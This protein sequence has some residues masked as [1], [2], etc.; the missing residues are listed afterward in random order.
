MTKS[1]IK[2]PESFTS[3]IMSDNA[4]DESIRHLDLYSRLLIGQYDRIPEMM[5]CS[6]CSASDYPI[7]RDVL[8]KIRCIFIPDLNHYGIYTSNGIWSSK[9]PERAIKAYDI[10][11]ALRFQMSWHNAK[12]NYSSNSVNYKTPFFHGDWKMTDEEITFCHRVLQFF[13]YPGCQ[14]GCS[15]THKWMLPCV[16]TEY[17]NEKKEIRLAMRC[18]FS[19]EENEAE[20][21]HVM[22][23]AQKIWTAT[24]AGDL[25]EV[26]EFEAKKFEH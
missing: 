24:Q 16:I 7:L 2:I 18:N 15:L 8:L 19:H 14:Q 13:N 11:Q 10:Q 22:K 20:I 12:P 9:S 17:C 4:I 6:V 26:S 3:I 23:A 5:G 21:I 25:V 1:H